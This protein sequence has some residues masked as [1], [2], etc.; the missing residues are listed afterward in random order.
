MS[1][2][3]DTGSAAERGAIAFFA[4][5][6]VAA[7]LLMLILVVWGAITLTTGMRT[8]V[9]PASNLNV[10]TIGVVYPGAAPEEI[11]EGICQRIEEEVQGLAGVEKVESTA[12]ESI[13]T[14]TVRVL[15]G[16]DVD[17]IFDE[18]KNRVGAI[19]SFPDEAEA[20]VVTRLSLVR[21]VINLAIAGDTDERSLKMVGERVRDDLL[22]TGK[23]TTA[24]LTSVRPYEISIEVAEDAL[25]RHGLTFAQVADAVRRS[26]LDLPGGSVKTGAGE[27]LLRAKSQA[28]RGSEFEQLV[29]LTRPDGSRV[30]LADVATVIDGFEDTDLISTFDG[31]PAVLVQVFRVGDQSAFDVAETVYDYV[32]ASAERLPPG[33]TITTW[34][35]DTAILRSRLDLLVRNGLSGLCLVFLSLALFLRFKLALWVT[36]GIPVSFLATF[37]VMPMG[38]IT[39]NMI[40]LFAFIVVLGIVVDDAI[41]VSENIY[42]HIQDGMPGLQ[43]AIHGAKQV[44]MPVIFSVL[45][46]MAAFVPMLDVAGNF[47]KVWQT[48]PFIVIATL[49]FSVIE[50]QLVLPTHLS[51]LHPV[52]PRRQ[53]V[54]ARAWSLIQTP[55]LRGLELFVRHVHGP[56]L[57]VAVRWRYVTLATF[58]AILVVTLG[59]VA[60]GKLPF[61]FLPDL[62]GDNAVAMLRM[63][64]GTP[65]EVTRGAIARLEAAALELRGELAAEGQHGVVQ[66]VLAS[67]GNQPFAIEQRRNAGGID[68]SIDGAH[69]GEVN[70]QLAPSESRTVTAESVVRRWREK[71]GVVP[72][73][74]ELSYSTAMMTAGEDINVRLSCPDFAALQAAAT[75]LKAELARFAGTTDITDSFRVGKR[76]AKLRLK[77]E[78]E[79]LGLTAATVAR[80]VRQGF[81]GEEAQ[82]IQRGREEVKVMVR[83]PAAE[84]RSFGD[85]EGMRLRTPAGDEIPFAAAVDVE[86]GRGYATIQRSDR[87]R[88]VNVTAKVDAKD[89]DVAAIVANLRSDTLP[90]LV[91]AHPR[92]TW[93]F[94]GQ[95]EEQAKTMASL[96]RGYLVALFAIFALIAIPFRSYLQPVIVM[97]AIPFGLVGAIW[98]HVVFG[99]GLSIMSMFGLVALTGVVVNDSIVLV[100]FVNTARRAGTDMFTAVMEA[101]RRRFRPIL[102]TSLT[103]FAGLLPLLF[104][105]SVQAKFL[106]PMAISLACGV[107]FSTAISLVLVPALYIVLE[108]LRKLFAPVRRAWDW[109]F[110]ETKAA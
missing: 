48:I 44:S 31:K 23:I 110:G 101:G 100:D 56:L 102:L 82:R 85:V 109:L 90:K 57:R 75:T 72:D 46:T 42:A 30:R 34:R 38:D 84:R 10:I 68:A 43:A 78:A 8:E 47:R 13:G 52:H 1:T 2:P 4:K 107:M 79:N 53:H 26:S 19:D 36:W 71:V 28:Y 67:V 103:T 18:V 14:V 104:E 55:F 3:T 97:T 64:Q 66:H 37:A 99:A 96:G 16:E 33:I 45:T 61:R 70:I 98:G 35:D 60:S 69:L 76:E 106:I 25:R 59:F 92:L 62:E 22:A 65:A 74:L 12:V 108:D 95:A 6:P 20:P 63:P 40:S 50:S 41:V 9:F 5:N 93:A 94:E 54:F 83:Y 15:E 86:E 91:A 29:L 89:G 77:P 39:I 21:Q 73:A 81:H 24:T 58:G 49:F 105:T 88:K 51:H 32:A 11:E 87:A 80:Q 7:N 27:I 17:K